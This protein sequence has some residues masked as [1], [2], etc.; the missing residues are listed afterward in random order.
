MKS[1]IV[2][3]L[4]KTE[5]KKKYGQ[6]EGQPNRQAGNQVYLFTNLRYLGY[7]SYI[8]GQ[9]IFFQLQTYYKTRL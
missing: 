4:V 7:G 6:T 2:Y 3:V 8:F 1:I 5:R 9:L